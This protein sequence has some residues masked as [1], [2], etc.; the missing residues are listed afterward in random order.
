[1]SSAVV[2]WFETEIRMAAPPRHTVLPS[3][4]AAV[5]L[6]RGDDRVREG[7]GSPPSGGA[8]R[9]SDLVSTTSLR[10]SR[11]LDRADALGGSAAS[12]QQRSMSSATPSRPRLRRAA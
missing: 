4:R 6:H 10:T 3:Q 1:M 11:A 8:K 12:A 9:T 5:G 2:R 7:V